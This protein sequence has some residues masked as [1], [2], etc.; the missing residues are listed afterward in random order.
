MN[1]GGIIHLNKTSTGIFSAVL[2][3]IFF[4]VVSNKKNLNSNVE[5]EEPNKVNLRKLVNIA[6]RAAENGGKEVIQ[7][8]DDIKIQKKGLTKEGLIDSVTTADFLSHCSMIRTLK[9]FY[10]SIKIISEEAKTICDN[11]QYVNFSLPNLVGE[12]ISD[13]FVE[14]KD[15]TVWVDPLDATY[16][17][18]GTLKLK[19]NFEACR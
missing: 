2:L 12:N 9:H 1:F 14:E 6:I 17:Y 19:Y 10:S 4:Y 13:E 16:E 18:T 5:I 7:R 15:V 8:K 11:D 3:F